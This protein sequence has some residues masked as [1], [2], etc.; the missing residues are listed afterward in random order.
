MGVDGFIVFAGENDAHWHARQFASEGLMTLAVTTGDDLART[1]ADRFD[2][3]LVVVELRLVDAT[4]LAA[5]QAAGAPRA[6]FIG[7]SSGDGITL[8]P[9]VVAY[10]EAEARPDEVRAAVLAALPEAQA[11]AVG[12]FSDRDAQRL[13]SLGREVE[14]IARALSDIATTSQNLSAPELAVDPAYVRAIIRRR[15]ERERFFPAELFSDPA[16]DMLLDLT[17]ARLERRQVSVSSLCIAAAVPTTTALR[18]IRNLCDLGL[19]ERN[20]DPDDMRRGLISLSDATADRMQ[21]YLSVGRAAG[22]VGI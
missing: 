11:V 10:L 2:I 15:R 13:N 6:I 18:W 8:N 9:N 19:F 22:T 14:R 5:L 7:A 21:A 4:L 3:A 20:I 12:D 17:A 1:L 16:W